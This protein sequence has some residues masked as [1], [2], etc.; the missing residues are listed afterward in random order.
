MFSYFPWAPSLS[1]AVD[2][3]V[4]E[5]LCSCGPDGSG[6]TGNNRIRYIFVGHD[7]NAL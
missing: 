5:N 3:A 2:S 6:G 1:V 4:L 7:F